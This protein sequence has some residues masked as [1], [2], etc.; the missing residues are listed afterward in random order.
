M[1]SRSYFPLAV[2]IPVHGT[3]LLSNQGYLDTSAAGDLQLFLAF[4]RLIAL[5]EDEAPAEL[6]D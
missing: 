1:F 4:L 2:C 3:I 6:Y 5:E